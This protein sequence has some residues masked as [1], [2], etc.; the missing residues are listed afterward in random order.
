MDRTDAIRLLESLVA[1]GMNTRA[2]RANAWIEK[3]ALQIGRCP[4]WAISG[5]MHRSNCD[6]RYC[7]KLGIFA[8]SWSG[9]LLARSH[10]SLND[11]R[12]RKCVLGQAATRTKHKDGRWA[13][14]CRD[15]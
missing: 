12:K 7:K 6:H 13:G 10:L 15:P 14:G 2:P 9:L 11:P 3:K 4:L 8:S 5:L 1:A